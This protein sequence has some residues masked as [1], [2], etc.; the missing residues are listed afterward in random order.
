MISYDEVGT[1][2]SHSEINVLDYLGLYIHACVTGQ[3]SVKITLF[4][5][6]VKFAKGKH[7]LLNLTINHDQTKWWHQ[8]LPA[9]KFR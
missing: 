4:R 9:G 3:N 7:L 2:T 6:E 1:V 5:Q 8:P